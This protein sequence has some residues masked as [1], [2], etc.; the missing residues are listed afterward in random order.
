MK[1][2]GEETRCRNKAAKDCISYV[3]DIG[4]KELTE[5]ERKIIFSFI[6]ENKSFLE[7]SE[8]L[9]LTRERV[10]QLYVR[11]MNKLIST[12]RKV[13]SRLSETAQLRL[14]LEAYKNTSKLQSIK[15]SPETF[16][17]IKNLPDET[18]RLLNSSIRDTNLSGRAKGM[19]RAVGM[20]KVCDLVA[21][22]KGDVLKWRT[23]GKK[24]AAEFD[25]F[26]AQ[27]NLRWEMFK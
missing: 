8:V 7:I 12:I 23:I 15:P 19:C 1:A 25:L 5:N 10:R 27:N 9:D 22:K 16:E 4:E 20:D 17:L 11:G 3:Y 21:L 13:E 18:K 6:F 24:T 2:T 26:L 14:D